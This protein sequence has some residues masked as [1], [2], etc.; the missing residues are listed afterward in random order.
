MVHRLTGARCQHARSHASSSASWRFG[1]ADG[2]SARPG[3]TCRSRTHSAADS[4]GR[5]VGVGVGV[6]EGSTKPRATAAGLLC[7]VRD[8]RRSARRAAAWSAP[9]ERRPRSAIDPS[10]WAMATSY[11]RVGRSSRALLTH[12]IP[13]RAAAK[14]VCL[15]AAASPSQNVRDV[16]GTA[17][18]PSAS[19][20]YY[21]LYC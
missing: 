16:A 10:I 9:I 11:K 6:G 12:P 19:G 3:Q 20:S 2:H 7:F 5:R 1:V 18:N 13:R 17:K 8:A 4:R 15:G 14:L 21:P